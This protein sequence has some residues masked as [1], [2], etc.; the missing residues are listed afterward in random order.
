MNDAVTAVEAAFASY[1]RKEA[2]MPPKVYLEFP[3]HD[4]DL[5]AMPAAMDGSAGLKW[6]NSHPSNP[7]RHNLPSVMG[8]YVL[9]DPATALPLALMDATLLTAV[10]TGAAAAVASKYLS[11]RHR[12]L[13]V[14]GCGAQADF[15][16]EAHRVCFPE[17]EVLA[18]DLNPDAARRVAESWG[19]RAVEVSEASGGDIVC[20]ATPSRTPVVSAAHVRPGAH[21][22]ALGA[23]AEGKQELDPA[24]LKAARVFV[25]DWAQ[26]SH[27][28]EINVPLASG[29]L[30]PADVQ[31]SVCEVVAGLRTGRIDDEE[32]TVFDSTGLAIQDL[33]LARVVYAAAKA[34]EVG[35]A[36][37]L[38]D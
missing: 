19:G 31:G 23:D 9:S 37:E 32:I 24:I 11:T 33:A 16:I 21:I 18:A 29:E 13:G 35:W 28:G 22:N 15:L 12:T 5:R 3:E 30:Q 17:I 14:I 20:T 6:V 26:A 27:S 8:L 38:R 10:R 1:G 2:Q 25:D 7:H 4:G 36:V 34:S